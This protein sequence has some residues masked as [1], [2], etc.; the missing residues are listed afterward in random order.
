[1]VKKAGQKRKKEEK[2]KTQLKRSKTS[3]GHH[4]PKGTNVTRA[5]VKVGKIVI[6]KQV[7]ASS[8]AGEGKRSAPVTRR[9]LTL[10]DLVNKLGHFSQSVKLDSLEGLK[11]LLTGEFGGNLVA[12]NLS[13]LITKIIPLCGDIEKKI[14]RTSLAILEAVLV[15]VEPGKLEPLYPLITAHLSCCLTNIQPAIQR[16]ALPIIDTL[17]NTAPDF[18]AANFSRILPDC[19]RQIAAEKTGDKAQSFGVSSQVTDKISSLE[20]RTSVLS[21][22]EKILQCVCKGCKSINLQEQHHQTTYEFKEHFSVGLYPLQNVVHMEK[23]NLNKTSNS[24]PMVD[25]VDKIVSLIL[26]TWIEAT[27]KEGKRNG[28][29]GFLTNDVHL[30]LSSISGVLEKLVAYADVFNNQQVFDILASQHVS[31][32][33][34]KLFCTLP[35]SS[36]NGKCSTENLRLC[37]VIVKFPDI[38]DEDIV[39]KIQNILQDS[40][41]EGPVVLQIYESLISNTQIEP[42]RKHSLIKLLVERSGNLPIG[43]IEWRQSLRLLVSLAKSGEDV[44][45]WVNTLPDQL[46]AATSHSQTNC[47]LRVM[48]DLAQKRD[49]TFLKAYAS[50]SKNIQDWRKEHAEKIDSSNQLL[51]LYVHQNSTIS[52][53]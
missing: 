5:E 24:D 27:G 46:L 7:E 45:Y 16:D 37:S 50:S 23:S 48:L 28:R 6:P 39:D 44:G 47:I 11:E 10:Q 19:I 4:L 22:V 31:D 43:S 40:R 25:L 30:L 32:L 41:A 21:R 1:M 17:A 53:S 3:P 52:V 36:S 20:W 18:I 51:L 8:S 38:I 34:Q 12:D 15:Q 26:D 35:Y 9:K 49:V 2:A 14:R 33:K 29:D 13:L 42:E